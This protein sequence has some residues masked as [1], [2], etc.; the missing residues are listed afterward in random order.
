MPR[1]PPYTVNVSPR[2]RG[3]RFVRD[4]RSKVIAFRGRESN[5]IMG[6]LYEALPKFE[7]FNIKFGRKK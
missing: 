3:R 4:D 2:K 1:R 7:M 5:Q 6:V